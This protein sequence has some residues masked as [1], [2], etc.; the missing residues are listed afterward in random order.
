VPSAQCRHVAGSRL[1]ACYATKHRA[2]ST[3]SGTRHT[4]HFAATPSAAARDRNLAK[5]EG[6]GA[7]PLR[8]R[9]A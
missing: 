8:T 1:I 5:H 9:T 4:G 7:T 2:M 6:S 3:A